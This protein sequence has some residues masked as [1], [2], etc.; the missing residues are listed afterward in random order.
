MKLFSASTTLTLAALA[1]VTTG[2]TSKRE[3]SVVN[4]RQPGPAIG[5]AIGTVGGAVVGNA[6]GAVVGAGEGF[7]SASASAFDSQRRVVRTWRNETTADGRTIRVPVEIEVDEYGRPY[8]NPLSS[9]SNG[10][11]ASTQKGPR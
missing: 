1:L 9:S 8:T 5:T 2:C 11:P 10:A 6:A 4:T 7:S 3:G